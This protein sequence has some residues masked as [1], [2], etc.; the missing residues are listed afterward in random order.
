MNETT[1]V[2]A[3]RILG[4]EGVGKFPVRFTVWNYYSFTT[5]E[6]F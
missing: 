3:K 5:S 2:K 6:D 4:G 1:K